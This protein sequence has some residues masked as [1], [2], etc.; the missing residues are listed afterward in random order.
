M[1]VN[2]NVTKE[3]RQTWESKIRMF[4]DYLINR[5]YLQEINLKRPLSRGGRFKT[6]FRL[7][8]RGN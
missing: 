2:T 8:R 3:L 5:L 1:H 6:Y 4:R 7:E